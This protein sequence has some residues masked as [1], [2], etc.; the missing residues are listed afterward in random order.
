V[1]Y[2]SL[3]SWD[4]SMNRRTIIRDSLDVVAGDIR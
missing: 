1:L 4:G 2:N 3:G